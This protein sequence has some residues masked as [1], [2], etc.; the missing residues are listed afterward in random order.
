MNK[1]I[2]NYIKEKRLDLAVQY[3]KA[4]IPITEAAEQAEIQ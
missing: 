1:T 2:N 3:L 4:D